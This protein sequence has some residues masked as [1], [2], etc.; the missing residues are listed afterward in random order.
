ME[1]I[2]L[3][4]ETIEE[5]ANMYEQGKTLKEI[6]L[7]FN[8]NRQIA[9]REVTAVLGH[10]RANRKISD[11]EKV[12]AYVL[13]KELGSVAKVARKMDYDPSTIRRVL[14]RT[15]KVD[16]SKSFRNYEKHYDEIVKLINKGV[17]PT[18]IARKYNFTIS[19]FIDY[20][21]YKG[22][23]DKIIEANGCV[24]KKDYFDNLDSNSAY[25]LGMFFAFA[26]E[27]KNKSMHK[28]VIRSGLQDKEELETLLEEI[29][30]NGN[31]TRPSIH[32]NYYDV[33]PRSN[34]LINK[35]F[36]YGLFSDIKGIP[37]HLI[38]SFWDGYF[39]TNTN[40]TKDRVIIIF[41]NEKNS[42][43]DSCVKYLINILGLYKESI[44]V[45][46]SSIKIYNKVEAAKV[47]RN[48][49]VLLDKVLEDDRLIK[50]RE[51]L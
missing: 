4:K 30:I 8:V 35:V 29:Y 7:K 28:I 10:T 15:Y 11:E 25:F 2:I 33:Y 50:F 22:I 38:K 26:K 13:Y 36:E 16:F 49:P 42:Y 32:S 20:L 46:S 27:P 41:L 31:F 3:D 12:M 17:K 37:N 47:I 9:S 45:E 24:I 19:R 21:V 5:M 51:K 6:A 1:K 40:I 48:H 14:I 44:I 34:H 39:L 18:L 43:I 23:Y